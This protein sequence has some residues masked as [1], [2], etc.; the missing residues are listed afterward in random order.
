MR[1]GVNDP[2]LLEKDLEI[3]NVIAESHNLVVLLRRNPP[4]KQVYFARVA[5]EI[6]RNLF[7][8]KRISVRPDFQA[9]LDCVVIGDRDKIHPRRLR[10]PV[11]L[12]RIRVAVRKIESAEDPILGAIA[13]FRV[14]MKVAAAHG[15][16]TVS[17]LAAA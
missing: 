13:K 10:P 17:V 3:K 7:T 4:D 12:L 6:S 2:F 11:E 14:Q 5:R 8:D 16:E 9:P 1:D 15:M